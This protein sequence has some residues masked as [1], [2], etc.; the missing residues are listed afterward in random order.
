MADSHRTAASF[1]RETFTLEGAATLRV[2]PTVLAFGAIAGLICLVQ[3]KVGVDLGIPVGPHEIAG[4]FLG[5]LLAL[6]TNTS[7]DRWWEA[8]KLWGGIVNQSRN[9]VLD[10]LAHGP[11]D[12][13][14]RERVVRWTA[15]F[16]HAARAQLRGERDVPELASLLGKDQAG[17]VTASEHLPSFV[18]LELAG[19]LREGQSLGM[20]DF[21]FLAAERERAGLIDHVGGCERIRNTP[22]ARVYSLASRRFIFGFLVLLPFAL[23]H[24]FDKE[25]DD[26]LVALVTMLVAYVLVSLDQ[27]G[28]ELQQP[29]STRSLSHLPLDEICRNLERNLLALLAQE[30]AER[31]A[32]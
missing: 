21:A 31:P 7:Y 22:L 28:L 23:L 2:L 4:A 26:W 17:R 3:H 6:R 1:W 8:R 20:S 5:V 18:A 32:S 29:F 9:L 11:A 15:A 30:K 10:A 27:I 16:A 24:K 12:A 19:L 13:R 25:W 14:W